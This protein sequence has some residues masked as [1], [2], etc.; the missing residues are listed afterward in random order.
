MPLLA[1]SGRAWDLDR[2]HPRRVPL[3]KYHGR[4]CFKRHGGIFI[5]ADVCPVCF[6]SDAKN[7]VGGGPPTLPV[8]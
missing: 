7:L 4:R 5:G 6:Q 1:V 3:T 2:E 8:V